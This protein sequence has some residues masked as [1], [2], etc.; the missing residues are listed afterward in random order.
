MILHRVLSFEVFPWHRLL[1]PIPLANVVQ[2][3]GS[4]GKLRSTGY[5]PCLFRHETPVVERYDSFGRGVSCD[6]HLFL[7]HYD[8]A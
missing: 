4:G 2:R 3:L 6:T 7:V 5:H 8:Q 1:V